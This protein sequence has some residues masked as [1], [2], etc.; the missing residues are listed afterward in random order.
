MVYHVFHISFAVSE[1]IHKCCVYGKKTLQLHVLNYHL[2]SLLFIWWVTSILNITLLFLHAQQWTLQTVCQW[3]SLEKLRTTLR[4]VPK[5]LKMGSNPKGRTKLTNG[6]QTHVM[7]S[8]GFKVPVYRAVVLNINA[9]QYTAIFL[10]KWSI[11]KTG[12]QGRL[13]CNAY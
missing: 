6:E 11:N 1:R 7:G 13:H 5:T 9:L 12:M 2:E 3:A 8:L 10:V 4:H